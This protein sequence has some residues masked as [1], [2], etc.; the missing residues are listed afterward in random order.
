MIAVAILVLSIAALIQWS[1]AYSRSFILSAADLEISEKTRKIVGLAD[2]SLSPCEFDHL[3]A[4]VRMAPNQ[5]NDAREI[6]AVSA[7]YRITCAA[8]QI[9]VLLSPAAKGMFDRELSRCSH[10]AA[11][12]L[13]RRL[14]PVA[15]A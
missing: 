11:V 9:A 5:I 1:V 15:A 8:S 7:Y 3:V 10:F 12:A 4:L 6:R 13:D 2:G 14:S